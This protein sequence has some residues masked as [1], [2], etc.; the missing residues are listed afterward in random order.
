MADDPADLFRGEM[1][2]GFLGDVPVAAHSGDVRPM[3]AERVMEEGLAGLARDFA[4]FN[5]GA[6]FTYG[7]LPE[8][9]DPVQEFVQAQRV[10]CE[11]AAHDF[12]YPLF[13][14]IAR[15]RHQ[16]AWDRRLLIVRREFWPALLPWIAAAAMVDRHNRV[17]HRAVPQVL[18]VVD[19]PRAQRAAVLT[20][21]PTVDITVFGVTGNVHRVRFLADVRTAASTGCVEKLPVTPAMRQEAERV[22]GKHTNPFR[23]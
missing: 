4:L 20:A 23:V 17:Y 5:H 16:E 2:E 18:S 6:L 12:A 9:M 1:L 14:G 13:R 8:G 11:V 15:N 22:F 21:V 3:P 19:Q 10:P 7:N